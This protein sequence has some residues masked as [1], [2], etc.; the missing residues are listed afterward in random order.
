MKWDL[1]QM[2]KTVGQLLIAIGGTMGFVS[3]GINFGAEIGVLF[4]IASINLVAHGMILT[5]VN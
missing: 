4:L 1:I 2:N 3:A 5:K